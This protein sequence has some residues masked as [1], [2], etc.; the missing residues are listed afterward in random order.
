MTRKLIDPVNSLSI[1]I[2]AQPGVYALLLGSGISQAAG[3]PTGWDITL[4][5]VA[6]LAH[7]DNFTYSTPIE[8]SEWYVNKNGKEPQYADLLAELANTRTARQQLLRSYFEP[9][10]DEWGEGSKQPT[11]AH[12][13]IAAL[14]QGGYVK[15]IVTTNFDRLLEKAL[16]EIG[17]V[18][19]VLSAGEQFKGAA[20]IHLMNCCVL[21]VNGDYLDP[22]IR[23]TSEE[24]STYPKEL[25]DLLDQIFDQYGLFV[26]GWS[27]EWDE[28]LRQ[29]LER[30]KGR[31]YPI[32]WAAQ[33]QLG[34]KARRLIQLRDAQQL[35]IVDADT[36]FQRV[37]AQV[38]ALEEYVKIHVLTTETAV[39]QIK[40]FLSDDSYR[41]RLSD[42]I[43]RVVDEV[44]ENT[45][46]E[47]FSTE[48]RGE[49]AREPFQHRIPA[50]VRACATLL[51]IAVL[52]GYWAEEN[53]YEFWAQA[54]DRFIAR[55]LSLSGDLDLVRLQTLPALFLLYALGL[56]AAASGRL[57]FL[58][59]LFWASTHYIE[60]ETGEHHHYAALALSTSVMKA[61]CF[62]PASNTRDKQTPLSTLMH[63][64]LAE[65]AQ[66]ISLQGQRYSFAFDK[67]EVLLTLHYCNQNIPMMY[68][69]TEFLVHR[70]ENVD[71]I[72]SEFKNSLFAGG[73][74]S[75]QAVSG[76]FGAT[77]ED[78]ISA[79]AKLEHIVLDVKSRAPKWQLLRSAGPLSVL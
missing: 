6:K 61:P 40:R 24:L 3:I 58:T 16:E 22:H 13:S 72:L 10:E 70:L 5:L 79:I 57:A 35:T 78:C 33:A 75:L 45:S 74:Q 43:S 44:L 60:G 37:G 47:L 56:G 65:A 2:Q 73:D 67:F 71:R 53:Q 62:S 26:C 49:N 39:A 66:R 12:H 69:P 23:N 28:A 36:L 21:K 52:G 18:P 55:P 42:L 11:E 14:V 32:Y 77:Q 1:S 64:T 38:K 7:L 41:I 27:A 8:L 20:P 48:F 31:R 9:S 4:D 68:M 15:V 50:Y 30:C 34:D 29:A 54:I 63:Q 46:S 59:R 19:T 17:I 25:N 76:I 51:P